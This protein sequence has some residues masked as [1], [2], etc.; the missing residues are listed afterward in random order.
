MPSFFVKNV[1]QRYYCLVCT[2]YSV[3]TQLQTLLLQDNN[4]AAKSGDHP[5]PADHGQAAPQAS[6]LLLA[7]NSNNGRTTAKKP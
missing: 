6:P 3:S 1:D 7:V 4:N 5:N 2:D